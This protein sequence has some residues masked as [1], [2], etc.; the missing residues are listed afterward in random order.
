MVSNTIIIVLD[1][2]EYVNKF[3]KKPEAQ[4]PQR[5]HEHRHHIFQ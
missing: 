2:F 1:F 5:D 3:Q 4:K